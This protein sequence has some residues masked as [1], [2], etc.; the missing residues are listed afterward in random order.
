M[1]YRLSSATKKIKL[2]EDLY[3][4]HKGLQRA[5]LQ[6]KFDVFL[7]VHHS[8]DIIQVTNLLHTSFIL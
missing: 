6:K 7:T 4:F 3:Q 2:M 8:I 1:I 5:W